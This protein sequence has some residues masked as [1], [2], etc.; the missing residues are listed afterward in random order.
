MGTLVDFG[1]RKTPG[2][3]LFNT[4]RNILR[5]PI[6]TTLVNTAGTSSDIPADLTRETLG[7]FWWRRVRQCY[8]PPTLQTVLS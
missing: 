2:V 1:I 8:T 4:C 7:N 3:V 5:S 6:V